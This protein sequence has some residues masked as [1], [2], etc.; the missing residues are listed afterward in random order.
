VFANPVDAA[1]Q[2]ALKRLPC[3]AIQVRPSTLRFQVGGYLF[4]QP[5]FLCRSP[6][7]LVQMP[8]H[9]PVI[10]YVT[11]LSGQSPFA[12][13]FPSHQ[14]QRGTPYQLWLVRPHPVVRLLS[15]IEMPLVYQVSTG[16]MKGG[17]V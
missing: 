11:Q 16:L 9:R 12:V 4:R 13:L 5:G 8:P 17:S 3:H 15:W 6:S 2:Y 10:Y 7:H 14:V 1:A